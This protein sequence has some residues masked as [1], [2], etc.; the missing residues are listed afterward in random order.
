MPYRPPVAATGGAKSTELP[1][2]SARL[3]SIDGSTLSPH[4]RSRS[5]SEWTESQLPETDMHGFMAAAPSGSTGARQSSVSLME[6]QGKIKEEK[7][8][9]ARLQE[10]SE[11]ESKLEEQIQRE[12]E[13]ERM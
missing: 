12:L 13:D 9:L 5:P 3:S 11:M 8:R 6:Q 1:A 10:L 7:A 2:T 4:E